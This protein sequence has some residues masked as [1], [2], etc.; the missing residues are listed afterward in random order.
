M[1][2]IGKY[3]G[4]Y[5]LE[6]QALNY[7]SLIPSFSAIGDLSSP[8]GLTSAVV[9]ALLMVFLVGVGYAAFQFRQARLRVKNLQRLLSPIDR[10]NLAAERRAIRQ[11][12]MMTAAE[13]LAY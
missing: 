9:L 3:K 5:N 13:T 8:A 6:P 7:Q 2:G 11:E 10:E 1:D 12:A 4:G